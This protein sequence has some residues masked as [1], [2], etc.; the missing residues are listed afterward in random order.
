MPGGVSLKITQ[1]NLSLTLLHA[2]SVISAL[3]LCPQGGS[4][5]NVLFYHL[6]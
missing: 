4:L 3:S 2:Q 6:V 1:L 5:L